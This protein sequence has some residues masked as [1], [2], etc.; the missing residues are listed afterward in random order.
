METIIDIEKEVQGLDPEFAE[1]TLIDTWVKGLSPFTISELRQ[2]IDEYYMNHPD[3]LDRTVVD[4][5]WREIAVKN[6]YK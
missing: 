3:E 1:H 6:A 5:M 4:V 2:K